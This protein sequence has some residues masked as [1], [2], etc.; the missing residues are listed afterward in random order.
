METRT[1]GPL[2]DRVSLLG[3]GFMRLPRLAG[4]EGDIDAARAC[5][6]VDYALEQGVNYFDTAWPYLDGLAE[7]FAGEALGRHNRDSFF[8]A[9]KLPVWLLKTREEALAIF[10]AQLERCRVSY[11]DYYLFHGLNGDTF[12]KMEAWNLYG[13]FR[14]LKQKGK[15]RH[16]GFSFHDRA[17]VIRRIANA[18]PWDFAQ[19]QINYLD[20]ETQNAKLQY[21]IL[22]G[23]GIPVVVM[24]PVKG[25]ALATLT[26]G[27]VRILK[28]QNAAASSASW[29]LR[30]AASLPGV[31]TVLSGMSNMEQV[32]DN[33]ATFK[34]FRPLAEDERETLRKAAAAYLKSG[35]IPCTGCRYCMDCPFGVDIP[36]N[37]AIYNQ[38]L[39]TKDSLQL[40]ISHDSLE[41]PAK[42]CTGCGKCVALC[43]QKID[44][45]AILKNLMTAK[46]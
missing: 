27:A 42:N 36:Q 26:D 18:H 22:S 31:L 33:T 11:F 19:I 25:G 3:Y 12:D 40:Y 45:P 35:A 9:T 6:L 29:A 34:H 7:P 46:G 37:I 14:K 24:E 41:R 43:P 39:L 17:E 30:Y 5:E 1:F 21:E 15:I 16:L 23:K 8:L 13:L 44:V 2:G 38:Y 20:W 28:K 4:N 32:K 10:E